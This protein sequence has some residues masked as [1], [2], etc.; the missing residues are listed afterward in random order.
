MRPSVRGWGRRAENPLARCELRLRGAC[1][2]DR[3]RNEVLELRR[4]RRPNSG[5]GGRSKR[6]SGGESRAEQGRAGRRGKGGVFVSGPTRAC[7]RPTAASGRP[8][9]E[10][11]QYVY[12]RKQGTQ[13]KAPKADTNRCIFS[14]SYRSSGNCLSQS[15][16]RG[17]P[18]PDARTGRRV[19]VSIRYRNKD[20]T[21]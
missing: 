10:L 8:D 19:D 17:K 15:E 13:K 16:K 2:P 7:A 4:A 5:S 18:C 12:G 21:T 20:Y 14:S 1:A 6:P 11:N 3:V 9:T